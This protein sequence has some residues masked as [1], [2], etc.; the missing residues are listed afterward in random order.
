MNRF[1]EHY[2]NNLRTE[3]PSM[4][5]K[6]P[7]RSVLI[8]SLRPKISLVRRSNFFLPLPLLLILLNLLVLVNAI[9]KLLHVG[10]IVKDFLNLC[11]VGRPTLN[12]LMATS[13]KSPSIALNISQYLFE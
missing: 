11:S 9:H 12:V 1:L 4:S 7:S 13:S 3:V 8:I 6:I 10:F 5:S 2:I